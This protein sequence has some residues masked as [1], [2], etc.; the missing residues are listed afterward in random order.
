[1]VYVLLVNLK[2]CKF[3]ITAMILTWCFAQYFFFD[4]HEHVLPKG[5]K[6]VYW[7]YTRQHDNQKPRNTK[8]LTRPQVNAIHPKNTLR[9]ETFH[10]NSKYNI[11]QLYKLYSKEFCSFFG[12]KL[13]SLNAI[14]FLSC[15][16]VQKMHSGTELQIFCPILI[17]GGDIRYYLYIFN[18]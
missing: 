2:F 12:A 5:D 10:L 16:T 17:F 4:T 13:Q 3:T 18:K 7:K 14:R 11:L 6:K 1:M 8:S 15:Q 9:G